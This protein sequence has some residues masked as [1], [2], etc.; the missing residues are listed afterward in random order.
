MAMEKLDINNNSGQSNGYI[1][2]RKENVDLKK[3]SV[4]TIEGIYTVYYVLYIE[5][6]TLKII[7]TLFNFIDLFGS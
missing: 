5:K 3:N 4:L 7:H 2:Y 1:V 6:M